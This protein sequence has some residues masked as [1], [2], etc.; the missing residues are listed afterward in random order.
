MKKILASILASFIVSSAFSFPVFAQEET[1][2]DDFI[3]PP[4][5]EDDEGKSE[6]DDENKIA[7]LCVDDAAGEHS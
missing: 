2:G 5:V 3:T 4:P 1:D 7:P 6:E